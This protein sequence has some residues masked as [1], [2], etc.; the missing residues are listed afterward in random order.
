V[1]EEDLID[2][3]Q[4]EVMTGEPK[5][6]RVVYASKIFKRVSGSR[7]CSDK[8]ELSDVPGG[9]PSVNEMVSR[10]LWSIFRL[11]ALY[12]QAVEQGII[13]DSPEMPRLW[14][15]SALVSRLDR[16]RPVLSF[17]IIVGN[18]SWYLIPSEILQWADRVLD[19]HRCRVPLLF[20]G[21]GG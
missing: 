9:P 21:E 10:D 14:I 20:G 1:L 7:N 17:S 13:T 16:V 19:Y 8:F 15:A 4:P 11:D 5:T 18:R 6:R 3:N 2:S 12:A